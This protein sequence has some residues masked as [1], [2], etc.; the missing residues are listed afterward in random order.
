M[1]PVTAYC[2]ILIIIFIQTLLSF[3]LVRGE[4]IENNTIN[5]NNNDHTEYDRY[6]HHYYEHMGEYTCPPISPSEAYKPYQLPNLC[7]KYIL[8]K[9]ELKTI[10]SQDYKI[11]IIEYHHFPIFILTVETIVHITTLIMISFKTICIILSFVSLVTITLTP[12]IFV[13]YK[14]FIYYTF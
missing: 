13:L 7:K 14:M 11:T 4:H 8:P 10:E 12:F 3:R 2:I 9:I 6:Y 5:S 1:S